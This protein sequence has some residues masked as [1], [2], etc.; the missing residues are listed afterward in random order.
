MIIWVIN[1]DNVDIFFVFDGG[2]ETRMI[3]EKYGLETYSDLAAVSKDL[4]F[5]AEYDFFERDD[6]YNALAE[7]YGLEFKKT[8][9]L[10]I[11]LKYDAINKKQIDAMNIFTTDGQLSIS[12]VKVLED[13]MARMN[14]LVESGE[15]DEKTVAQEF[16]ASKG[17]VSN[18]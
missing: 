4:V 16:L 3:A 11:G 10:D 17:L 5:G 6:G 13:D 1:I 18:D 8:V 15:S 14:Y 9:D 7:Q 12:D 2:A